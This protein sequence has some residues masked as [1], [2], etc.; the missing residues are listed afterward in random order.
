MPSAAAPAPAA[1]PAAAIAV[2]PTCPGGAQED[3]CDGGSTAI[4]VAPDAS[5]ARSSALCIIG[6]NG[7]TGVSPASAAAAAADWEEEAAAE[8]A[9]ADLATVDHAG[10]GGVLVRGD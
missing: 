4:G 7:A 9:R 10:G 6:T 8:T 3:G 1:A 5:E 2:P